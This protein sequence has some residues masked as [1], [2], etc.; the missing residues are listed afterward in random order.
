MTLTQAP[1]NATHG[2]YGAAVYI[3][4]K[5]G[6]GTG[7]RRGGGSAL[8]VSGPRPELEIRGVRTFPLE[9]H[10]TI[11]PT[12]GEVDRKIFYFQFLDGLHGAKLFAYAFSSDG[13]I[14]Q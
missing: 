5:T 3:G 4:S 10:G 11:F 14:Q 2:V 9:H 8:P 12:C 6:N 1:E 7:S 13:T